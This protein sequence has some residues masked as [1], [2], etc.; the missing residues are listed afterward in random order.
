MH[1]HPLFDHYSSLCRARRDRQEQGRRRGP[2]LGGPGK[3]E[4]H[5]ARRTGDAPPGAPGL[6][7]LQES[8]PRHRVRRLR[9]PQRV[10]GV[11]DGG[12]DAHGREHL[13][14]AGQIQP[15]PVRE[16]VGVGCAA[17]LLRRLWRRPEDL[18]R[19][20]VRQD[21]DAGGVAL[22]AEAL[23]V[24]ALLQG[25]HLREGPHAVAAA[26]PADRTC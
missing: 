25:E 22:P 24:E 6:R 3:D 19:H 5:V 11:L 10:A 17:V 4:A 2:D 7:Q 23:Q 12:R 8:D 13:P 18:R 16:P 20:G 1:G 26:R 15:V 14:R 9:H 21:R